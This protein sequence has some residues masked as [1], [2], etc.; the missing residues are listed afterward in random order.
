MKRQIR[1]RN[2]ELLAV[3]GGDISL[4]ADGKGVGQRL[5]RSLGGDNKVIARLLDLSNW[6]DVLSDLNDICWEVW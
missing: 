5:S 4:L 1:A 6:L 2:L 3:H